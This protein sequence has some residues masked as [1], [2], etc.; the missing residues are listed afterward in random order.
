MS[1]RGCGFLWTETSGRVALE[2]SVGDERIILQLLAIDLVV[3][4]GSDLPLTIALQPGIGPDL[5]LLRVGMPFVFADGVLAAVKDC[6]VFA[7]EAHPGIVECA[8]ARRVWTFFIAK[9]ILFVV[10]LA[11]SAGSLEIVGQQLRDN[12]I[13]CANAFGPL[14]L[15]VDHELRSFVVGCDPMALLRLLG[16]G[17]G[18]KDYDA[19]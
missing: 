2:S 6:H 5:A 1:Q 7:E 13:I 10:A 17:G 18:H 11:A 14:A 15:H 19:H 3:L 8:A 16:M 9:L 12:S 4:R